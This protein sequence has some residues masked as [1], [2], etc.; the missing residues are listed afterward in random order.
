MAVQSLKRP[1]SGY[2]PAVRVTSALCALG[3]MFLYGMSRSAAPMDGGAA[4]G[5][6]HSSDMTQPSSRLDLK[7]VVGRHMLSYSPSEGFLGDDD[8]GD[9]DSTNCSSPRDYHKDYNDSCA[10]VRAEC[11]DQAQ[12]FDYLRLVMCDLSH[13]QVRRT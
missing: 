11:G 10:Y 5:D 4:V 6:Q 9:D 3:V 7:P 2:R 12:L 8:V 1:G 13:A